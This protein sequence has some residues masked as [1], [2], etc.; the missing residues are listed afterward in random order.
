M[1]LPIYANLNN[2]ATRHDQTA[3]VDVDLEVL[4]NFR[5]RAWKVQMA[6]PA[7]M[8]YL[9]PPILP[10]VFWLMIILILVNSDA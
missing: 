2:V 5:R 1:T 6:K 10:G 9:K 3:L 8:L 7:S 4:R